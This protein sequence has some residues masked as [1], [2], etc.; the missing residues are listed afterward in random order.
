M[1]FSYI[2][3]LIVLFM[4]CTKQQENKSVGTFERIDPAL[5]NI[6]SKDASIEIIAEGY[7]WSEGPVWVESQKMLLF[8]DVPKNTIYKWTEAKGAEVYLTPSGFTGDSTTS[9]EPGSNGLMLD[10]LS[11]QDAVNLS[12]TTTHFSRC[13]PR[14]RR[15]LTPVT[16]RI[17][18]R[19]SRTV[20]QRR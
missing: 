4:G 9:P 2:F 19:L 5:E 10:L 11:K 3:V 1:K 17:F 8:S 20:F 18:T 13:S 7:E 15:L 6:I 16:G 14:K 12:V